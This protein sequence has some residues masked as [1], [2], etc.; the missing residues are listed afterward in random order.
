MATTY[1]L[2]T[3]APVITAAGID[4]PTFDDILASLQASFRSIYGPDIYIAEDSQDGQWIAVLAKAIYDS[5][6]AAVAVF[7]SFSPTYSFG[8]QLSSLVKL[9]GLSRLVETNSTVQGTVGGVAGTIITDG[10]VQDTSGNLWNL[11]SPVTIP[12]SGSLTVTATAQKAGAIQATTGAVNKIYNPQYG[13]QS[14]I[15]TAPAVT[16]APVETDAELRI[17]QSVSTAQPALAIKDSIDAG[18][19]QVDGVVRHIVYEN[20]TGSTDADGIPAHSMA[21]VIKGGVVA[22][23]AAAIAL[24]KPPGAQTYG[25]TSAAVYD[26]NGLATTI[27]WFALTEKNVYFAVTIKALAGYVATTGDA[28]K[29]ALAD[30]VNSLDIGEDVY[31][32]QA[33]AAAALSGQAIGQTFY[34]TD[35]RLGFAAAPTGTTNLTVAFNEAAIG[36]SANTGLAV[37]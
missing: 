12:V 26:R 31:Y 2:A 4:A 22:D 28:I 17:R 3:L 14:F 9:N 35:F 5:N 20:D 37:T 6:Q 10:V 27:N 29:Q 25:T 11:P 24:R 8:A 16:G 21:A 19:G 7:Q 33:Y 34:I 30:F 36:A 32:S 13:W 1:P 23:I 18:I 15:N